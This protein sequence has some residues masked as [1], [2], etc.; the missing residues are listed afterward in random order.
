MLSAGTTP[1]GI[2]DSSKVTPEQIKGD[3]LHAGKGGIFSSMGSGSAKGPLA[4][5]SIKQVNALF[6]TTAPADTATKSETCTAHKPEKSEEPVWNFLDAV[7]K[8]LRNFGRAQAKEPTGKEVKDAQKELVFED[9]AAHRLH[10]SGQDN[11]TGFPADSEEHQRMTNRPPMD[12][13]LVSSK[14]ERLGKALHD[15]F[16]PPKKKEEAESSLRGKDSA[17]MPDGEQV[18]DC[19]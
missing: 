2:P 19:P 13:N 16:V 6:T 3:R 15:T 4:D 5:D 1:H 7:S 17:D 9:P 18:G 14:V 8:G 10:I 12:A 11:M